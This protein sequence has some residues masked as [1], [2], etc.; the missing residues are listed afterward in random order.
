M[1][2]IIEISGRK[3][4]PQCGRRYTDADKK[5]MSDSK[6]KNWENAEYRD[7]MTKLHI[8][9]KAWNKGLSL[10]LNNALKEWRSNGGVSWNKGKSHKWGKHTDENRLKMREIALNKIKNGTH[11]LIDYN[12]I[13]ENKKGRLSAKYKIWRKNVFERDAYTCMICDKIG[14]EINPHH[15]ENYAINKEKRYDVNNGITLCKECHFQFHKKYGTKY[16][17]IMQINEFKN[18]EISRSDN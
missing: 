12:I 2:F 4:H 13:S 10:Q 9:Q 14:G 7:K 15:I 5:K 16:N 11:N 6:K 1:D 3:T 8:G 18:F 17:N